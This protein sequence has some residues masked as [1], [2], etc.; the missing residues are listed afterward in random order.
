MHWN[1]MQR[2]KR[3]IAILLL[4]GV[5][6]LHAQNA[7]VRI[8]APALGWVL[9]HDG[10]Q[11]IAITGVTESPRDGEAISLP[12]AASRIWGSPQGDR[13][14][15]A[16]P[17]GT[18]LFAPATAPQRILETEAGAA[19]W[20]RNGDVVAACLGESCQ[21]F[22]RAGSHRFNLSLPEGATL[23]ALQPEGGFAFRTAEGIGIRAGATEEFHP[24]AVA[25][26]FTP[27]GSGAWVLNKEGV[28]AGPAGPA[29]F[30]R[31]AVGMVIALDGSALIAVAADGSAAAFDP[32]TRN[33]RH[34]ALEAGVDGVWPAPGNWNVRLHDSA[35]RP[36]AFWSGETSAFSWMPEV[37]Q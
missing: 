4:I 2:T 35:K 28:L 21:V 26:A 12:G 29:E 22:E 19:V 33:V 20:S 32:P 11:V 37:R 6:G 34:F 25:I 10:S 27:D 5:F 3:G 16:L 23:A 9:S 30:L 18:W 7:S 24:N 14:V 15:A 17:D 36:I 1:N 8:S 31:N 13:F